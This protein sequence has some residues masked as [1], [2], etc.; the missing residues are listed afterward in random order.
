MGTTRMRLRFAVL[1]AAVCLIGGGAALATPGTGNPGILLA[2]A[3]FAGDVKVVQNHSA[4]VV[5]TE[6][7]FPPL[8]HS[9]W[10][11]HPGTTVIAVKSGAISIYTLQAN[12]SCVNNTYT[13]GQGFVEQAGVFQIGKN[14]S[15]TDTADVFVTFFNVPTGGANRIDLPAA[16]VPTDPSCPAS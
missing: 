12:G 2:R 6:N 14:E 3:T 8:T 1:V 16:S 11:A 15:T 7:V 4:D 9:G 5:M 13:A 10:H